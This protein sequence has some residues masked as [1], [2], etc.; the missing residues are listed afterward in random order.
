[1]ASRRCR[2]FRASPSLGG[3]GFLYAALF[4]VVGCYLPYLPVWLHWRSLDADAIA[5]LL[6]A[7]LFTRILFTP[8]HQLCRRPGGGPADHPHRARLGLLALVPAAVGRGR[9]LADAA[10]Q[11]PARHQLDHDHAADRDRGGDRHPHRRAGLWPGQAVGLSQLHRGEPRR[12]R[13]SSARS[14][15]KWCCRCSSRPRRCWCSAPISCRASSAG[16]GSAAPAVLRGL[17]LADAFDLVRAPLFLLF[18]LAA[19]LIQASHALYYSFGTLQ[20][21][22]ARHPRRRDRRAVVGG[23]GGRGRAVRGLGPRHRLLRH[24]AAAHAG[25]AC[26]EFALGRHGV[27]P[28]ALGDRPAPDAFTP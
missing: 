23:R 15:R 25:G 21:A 3:S 20:L 13:R 6:A 27:R 5:V 7:P 19:S 8:R 18:L 22:G 24:G 17:K 28:A 9:V 10:R 4:L 12:G 16:S 26:G 1:M 2:A 11:R 14:G